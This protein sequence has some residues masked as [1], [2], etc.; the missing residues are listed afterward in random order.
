MRC[1]QGFHFFS[2]NRSSFS[3]PKCLSSLAFSGTPGTTTAMSRRTWRIS[4]FTK[5]NFSA[6]QDFVRWRFDQTRV[7]LPRT[8]SRTSN[9]VM[10]LMMMLW[11]TK[12]RSVRWT[13]PRK[14]LDL[15][16]Y[17]LLELTVCLCFVVPVGI[18]PILPWLKLWIMKASSANMEAAAI[19]SIWPEIGNPLWQRSTNCSTICG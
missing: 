7:R 3:L 2:S 4:S 6:F 5:T 18:T 19:S 14:W 15:R 16:N 8:S 1:F 11:R 17:Q 10:R 9:N 13:P 12:L